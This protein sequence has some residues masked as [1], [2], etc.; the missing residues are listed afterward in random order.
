M[1]KQTPL[2]TTQNLG[3]T[4]LCHHHRH[5]HVL[6]PAKILHSSILPKPLIFWLHTTIPLARLPPRHRR[7]T[8]W[9]NKKFF[10]TPF[11]HTVRQAMGP[12]WSA[13]LCFWC[14]HIFILHLHTASQ[15]H[16]YHNHTNAISALSCQ[17]TRLL[18]TS[19][20]S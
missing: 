16:P 6:S 15:D 12:I 7:N 13:W 10:Q 1:E 14:I 2:R 8:W 9:S 11:W 20:I 4:S 5:A 3:R 18:F 19:K 17:R